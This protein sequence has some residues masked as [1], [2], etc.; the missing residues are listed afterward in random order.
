MQF[1]WSLQK[2]KELALTVH[3]FSTETNLFLLLLT[4]KFPA[5]TK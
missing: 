4:W 1:S 5:L 2:E 3:H